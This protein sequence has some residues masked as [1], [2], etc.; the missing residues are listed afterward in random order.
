MRP[1]FFREYYFLSQRLLVKFVFPQIHWTNPA[2]KSVRAAKNHLIS[3]FASAH[4]DFLDDLWDRLLPPTERTL[5]AMRPCRPEPLTLCLVRP[6]PSLL[7]LCLLPPH[8]PGY[9]CL[10]FNGPD[11]RLSWDPHGDRVYYLGPALT[12]HP[13]PR[14][15]PPPLFLLCRVCPTPTPSHLTYLSPP[16]LHSR[17]HGLNRAVLQRTQPRS[18][19]CRRG[20]ANPSFGAWH[21]SHNLDTP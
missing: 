6:P 17:C 10:A 2:E 18:L 7:R 3:T 14:T 15:L 9:L 19:P 11:Y 21:G 16:F 20:G 5:N 1:R 12:H 8:P 13:Y 4:L